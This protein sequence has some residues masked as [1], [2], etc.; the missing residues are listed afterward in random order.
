MSTKAA[1][2]GHYAILETTDATLKRSLAAS[3]HYNDYKIGD[4]TGNIDGRQGI[5]LGYGGVEVIEVFNKSR[6]DTTSELEVTPSLV[7]KQSDDLEVTMVT[8]QEVSQQ[9]IESVAEALQ[10][11]P[12]VEKEEK[13]EETIVPKRRLPRRVKSISVDLELL[14]AVA[15]QFG[16]EIRSGKGQGY[17]HALSELLSLLEQDARGGADTARVA[18]EDSDHSVELAA[19]VS[20]TVAVR[21]KPWLGSQGEWQDWRRKLLSF[22]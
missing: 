16:I 10:A 8:T 20:Q 5:K 14:K 9:A 22:R 4:R 17:D 3:R 21:Q 15:G 19:P 11:L 12:A 1:I 6:P 7:D 18:L 13:L 2:Q